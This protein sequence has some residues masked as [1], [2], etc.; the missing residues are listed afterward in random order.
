MDLFER[1]LFGFSACLSRKIP[2]MYLRFHD[3][4][5]FSAAKVRLLRLLLRP[6]F[7][8]QITMVPR[9]LSLSRKGPDHRSCSLP[10]SSFLKHLRPANSRRGEEGWLRF[11]KDV[12]IS[13]SISLP[14]VVPLLEYGDLRLASLERMSGRCEELCDAAIFITSRIWPGL[15]FK[16][17]MSH[18][19]A[20]SER[21]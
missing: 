15:T 8:K 14:P 6:I 19:R 10:C 9:P 4:T 18:R 1:L 2:V 12:S 21:E 5:I 7:I 20:R 11:A 16:P 13:D 17:A 3:E